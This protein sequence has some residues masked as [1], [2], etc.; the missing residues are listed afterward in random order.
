MEYTESHSSSLNSP[1]EQNPPSEDS[2]DS[3]I[4]DSD[5]NMSEIVLNI[6]L[7]IIYL[8]TGEDYI[9]VK[10][11]SDRVSEKS[12][13]PE[14]IPMEPP[15]SSLVQ[16]RNNEK[17]LELTSKI[18]HLLTDNWEYSED[19]N[20]LYDDK[21]EDSKPSDS[22]GINIDESEN[23]VKTEE[24][25]SS[26]DFTGKAESDSG[27]Q[28]TKC[29]RKNPPRKLQSRSIADLNLICVSSDEESKPFTDGIPPLEYSCTPKE[30]SVSCEEAND[31]DHYTT[32]YASTF[33]KE[34]PEA[35]E[36]GKLKDL[37]EPKENTLIDFTLPE[38]FTAKSAQLK[39]AAGERLFACLYCGK[40]FTG[41]SDLTRHKRVHTGERPFKCTDC[42]K[43][44]SHKSNLVTHQKLH[45]GEKAYLCCE[46]GR[47]FTNSSNLVTHQRGHRGDKPYSCTDCG[48]RFTH[49]SD[50]VKHRR[51]HTGE[52]PFSCRECGKSFT[53]TSN[54]VTHRRI[55]T[56]EKPFTCSEC[57]KCFISN[58]S[59]IK[60]ER[61]HTGNKPYSC[62]TCGKRFTDKSNLSRH[63]L[64][65]ID[66]KARKR[67]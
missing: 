47:S 30:E 8:L 27:M 55:H 32:H 43:C 18:I 4:I 10:K 66:K 50:L 21:E 46:C 60:H 38:Q 3:Q 12:K 11:N 22:F 20:D 14:R 26:L 25:D 7:E 67:R 9:I 49:K 63:K 2:N 24:V 40:C 1:E 16:C 5:K 59:L 39:Y 34:E 23:G 31:T 19:N 52:K 37:Y 33:I 54:L 17:I 57:G 36:E 28:K 15:P 62:T 29:R 53:N 13:K 56:G 6:T 58:A 64:T 48:K 41:N 61:I 42:G 35:F 45:T 65:H 44:F 51:V